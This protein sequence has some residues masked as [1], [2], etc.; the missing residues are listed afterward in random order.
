MEYLNIICSHALTWCGCLW[1]CELPILPGWYMK[2]DNLT[3][4][5]WGWKVYWKLRNSWSRCTKYLD[6]ISSWWL[7]P[8]DFIIRIVRFWIDVLFLPIL[9]PHKII[10]SWEAIQIDLV[11]VYCIY[12][13]GIHIFFEKSHCCD[14]S[15]SIIFLFISTNVGM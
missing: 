6:F 4:I 10:V 8:L 11:G 15:I 1:E 9:P 2:C 7:I 5:Y 14:A 3:S 13:L 12:S